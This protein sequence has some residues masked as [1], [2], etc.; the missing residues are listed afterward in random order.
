VTGIRI[1]LVRYTPDYFVSFAQALGEAGFDVH[2]IHALRSDA[3]H[4]HARGHDPMRSLDTTVG[5][6]PGSLPTLSECRARLGALEAAAEGPR[7][8]DIILMD[9]LLRRKPTEFALRYLAHLEERVTEFLV[10]RRIQLVT[11]GRD[12]ALQ[13]LVMLV[14]RKLGIPWVVPT[15]ARIPQQMYGFCQRH[16]TEG[17][18]RFRAR[19]EAAL[20]WAAQT[21]DAFLARSMR[22]ALKKSARGFG[23]VLRLLPGHARVFAYEAGRARVDGGNDWARYTLPQMA[24]M[25]LQRR[26]NLL[27]YRFSRPGRSLGKTP[28]CLYALHTQPESSIDVVGSYF[29][30]QVHLVRTIARSIPAT[31]ELVVKIHPTDVDGKP[32]S[33]YRALAEIPGVRLVGHEEDSHDLLQRTSLLFALSGTI[34]YEAGLMGRPV[35]AF[36]RNYFN[37]L[38][39]IRYC[40]DPTALAQVVAQQIDAPPPHDLR[41]RTVHFLADLHTCCFEGEVNRTYGASTEGLRED[42]LA[43]LQRA[44]RA[45]AAVLVPGGRGQP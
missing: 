7:I 40:P 42:D 37:A 21:L 35:I 4:L 19:D 39:T 2:W 9:R 29:S 41:E 3:E 16:D 36:A 11:S 28:F 10:S 25:Y 24:R 38:P 45:L 32:S 23:D 17:L 12:T 5:F 27:A 26:V 14:C 20:A 30:D 34:A 18:I 33:F 22:P 6:P 44:Y 31:H 43:A 13:L 8:H 1:A 15:R